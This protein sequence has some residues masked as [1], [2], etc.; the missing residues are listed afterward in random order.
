MASLDLLLKRRPRGQGSN[1]ELQ[2]QSALPPGLSGLQILR[3]NGHWKTEGQPPVPRDT[4]TL[5]PQS[6]AVGQLA[7]RP[8]SADQRPKSRRER[9]R[10][11]AW[12]GSGAA[13][14]RP[15]TSDSHRRSI[16]HRLSRYSVSLQHLGA[17]E[18]WNVK[19][20]ESE[21]ATEPP[22][23]RA[24]RPPRATEGREP[25]GRWAPDARGLQAALP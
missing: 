9:S 21:R 7:C 1:A 15:W 6:H 22:W 19:A 23:E 24:R 25:G 4:E 17:G 13:T 20:S 10:G 11:G 12:G 16:P 14:H 2:G 5:S 8:H 18:R 3:N